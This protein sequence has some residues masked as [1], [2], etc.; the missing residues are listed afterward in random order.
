MSN[1]NRSVI[2]FR[3][4]IFGYFRVLKINLVINKLKKIENTLSSINMHPEFSKYLLPS[5]VVNPSHSETKFIS[6]VVLNLFY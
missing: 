5:K 3:F 2:R 1:M 4:N 6:N